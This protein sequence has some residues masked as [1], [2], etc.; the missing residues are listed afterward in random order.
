MSSSLITEQKHPPIQ[1]QSFVQRTVNKLNQAEKVVVCCLVIKSQSG[2]RI[3]CVMQHRKGNG[4]KER[5][6]VYALN[7]L[8]FGVFWNKKLQML[9]GELE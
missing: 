2:K 1:N 9:N 5:G 4:K 3:G 8:Y 7:K 6:N